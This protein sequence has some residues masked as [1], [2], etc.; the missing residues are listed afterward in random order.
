MD[1][2]DFLEGFE[3]D[4]QTYQ[5]PEDAFNIPGPAMTVKQAQQKGWLAV[6]EDP[7]EPDTWQVVHVVSGK[8]LVKGKRK[9]MI[10]ALNLFD[11]ID[12]DWE[13]PET[14]NLDNAREIQVMYDNWRKKC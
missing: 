5:F 12:I 8:F 9:Y 1:F 13:H 2:L 10:E 11:A 6:V 3:V 14:Q 7:L 4:D